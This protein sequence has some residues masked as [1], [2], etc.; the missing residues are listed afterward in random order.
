MFSR[1]SRSV[2]SEKNRDVL[3]GSLN[4]RA[5]LFSDLPVRKAMYTLLHLDSSPLETSF[6][7]ELAQEFVKTWK[8][9]H[10]N[11]RVIYRDLAESAP[12]PLDA[13]WISAADAPPAARTEEQIAVLAHSE[14]LIAELEQA[15]EYVISVA[16]HNLSIPSTLRLWVD[17]ISRGGRTFTFAPEGPVGLLKG[18]RATMVVASGGV[19]ELGTPAGEY[20]FVEP[21]LRAVLGFLGITDVTFVTAGG[22]AQ[23]AFGVID[24]ETFLEPLLE[25][26]REAASGALSGE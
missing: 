21:Y 18:K 23:V 5:G 26:V 9:R 22:S 6:S 17:Q 10:E 2:R 11:G 13:A 12:K 25:K 16:M 3:R 24:R 7:R 8:A 15:D 1:F 20:N 14:E 19:Y 4:S